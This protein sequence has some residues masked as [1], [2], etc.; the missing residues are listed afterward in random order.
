[1]GGHLLASMSLTTDVIDPEVNTSPVVPPTNPAALHLN[2]H[3]PLRQP[4]LNM[5]WPG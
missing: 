5:E 1:M 2:G 4:G 3:V